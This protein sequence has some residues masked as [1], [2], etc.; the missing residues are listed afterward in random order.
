MKNYII[1]VLGV[2]VVLQFFVLSTY[3]GCKTTT[4]ENYKK[5]AG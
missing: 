5:K 4:P 1:V 2:G 3:S